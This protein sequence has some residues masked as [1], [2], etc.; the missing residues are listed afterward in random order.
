M[1]SLQEN[2]CNSN[3]VSVQYTKEHIYSIIKNNN[4][5][6]DTLA[7]KLCYNPKNIFEKTRR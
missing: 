1:P 2:T 7:S 6:I 4:A 3:N 5:I